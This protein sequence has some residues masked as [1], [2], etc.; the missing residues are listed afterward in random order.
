MTGT[1]SET[2][3][4]DNRIA[5]ITAEN[6]SS[7]PTIIITTLIQKL[8]T[9]LVAAKVCETEAGTIKS[10]GQEFTDALKSAEDEVESFMNSLDNMSN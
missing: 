2:E 7:K 5:F 10:A 4:T 6:A 9:S 3:V 1:Y 8:I